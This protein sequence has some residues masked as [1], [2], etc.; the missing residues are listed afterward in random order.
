MTIQKEHRCFLPE[1][2]PTDWVF[3]STSPILFKSNL[4]DGDWEQ[5][6]HFNEHQKFTYD[7][8]FCVP[9]GFNRA[10][11]QIID[12]LIAT[13]QVPQSVVSNLTALNFMDS[14]SDDGKP[15]F[16]SSPLFTGSLT[17]NG[18]NGNSFPSVG[19]VIRKNGLQA[20]LDRPF[21]PQTTLQDLLR[22]PTD[23]ELAKAKQ[24][25][26]LFTFNYHWGTDGSPATAL[27]LSKLRQMSPLVFGVAVGD[28]W[29]KPVP[30]VPPSGSAP[31]HCVTNPR[32]SA[33]PVGQGIDDNYE[34]FEK[35]LTPD[36]PVNYV[37]QVFVGVVPQ[38]PNPPPQPPAVS[39]PITPAQVEQAQSWLS[40]V[41]Q[42]LKNLLTH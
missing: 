30:T 3:G 21:T 14:N 39:N 17:G 23:G 32:A 28:G 20:W 18:Q 25:L 40:V 11:D 9:F 38:I 41:A 12:W 16:H 24:V 22:K 13:G 33:S 5:Y 7:S 27:L 34:P 19:D 35:V 26:S 29:N 2:R 10:F 15:H 8:D 31:A 4:P 36:Y 6:H 42:W 37:M 1:V